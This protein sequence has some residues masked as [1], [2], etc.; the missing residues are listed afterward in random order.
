MNDDK[1]DLSLL[2]PAR[3][4]A[5]WEHRIQSIVARAVAA[6]RWT[7]A[8]QL[9]RWARPA[10]GLAA[11]ATLFS[12]AGLALSLRFIEPR[13]ETDSVSSEEAAASVLS[14]W[15]ATE[16]TPS[17]GSILSVLGAPATGASQ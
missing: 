14:R 16:A 17:A 3:E 15:V 5:R 7:V 6:Q 13:A 8:G 11:A 9:Q 4:R 12:W 10:L 2:D 1:L